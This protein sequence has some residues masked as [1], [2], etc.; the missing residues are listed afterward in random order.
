LLLQ[1]LNEEQEKKVAEEAKIKAEQDK[2]SH[3]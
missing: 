1:K 2:V 3:E